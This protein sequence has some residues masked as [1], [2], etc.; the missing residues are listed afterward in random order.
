MV[1]RE[2]GTRTGGDVFEGSGKIWVKW[3]DCGLVCLGGAGGVGV[4]MLS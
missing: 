1:G 4:G 3:R 2:V